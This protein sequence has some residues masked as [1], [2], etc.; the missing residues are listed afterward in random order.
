MYGGCLIVHLYYGHA[1]VHSQTVD[2][3]EPE[4]DHHRQHIPRR[5][6]GKVVPPQTTAA[7]FTPLPLERNEKSL[8]IV[9]QAP[10][11]REA[12][13]I[14]SI[15]S[16]AQVTPIKWVWLARQGAGLVILFTR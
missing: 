8:F 7:S 3:G 12:S 9:Y 13:T 5:D 1:E 11:H 15:V 16:R 14:L 10:D 4:G 2:Y 6:A